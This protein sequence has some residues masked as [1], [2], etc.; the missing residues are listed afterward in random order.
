MDVAKVTRLKM[1][2]LHCTVSSRHGQ[3][4]SLD[5]TPPQQQYQDVEDPE[6][7]I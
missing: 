5:L 6:V 1:V 7:A 4:I 3:L 2:F